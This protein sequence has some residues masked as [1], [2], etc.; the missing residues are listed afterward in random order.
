[1]TYDIENKPHGTFPPDPRKGI[2]I[3]REP[4]GDPDVILFAGAEGIR[5]LYDAAKILSVQGYTARIVHVEDTELFENQPQEYRDSVFR[6][7]CNIKIGIAADD[8]E[9]ESFRNYSDIILIPDATVISREARKR[10][11][12]GIL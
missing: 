9:K 5:S 4:K 1:M 11:L 3:E 2:Y 10:I 12:Q 6:D 8:T 7:G